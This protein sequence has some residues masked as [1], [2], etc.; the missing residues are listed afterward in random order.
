M[1]PYSEAVLAKAGFDVSGFVTC[2][3]K[4]QHVEEADLVLGLEREHR[5]Y[6]RLLVPER[7]D[8]MFT[9]IEFALLSKDQGGVTVEDIGRQRNQLNMNSEFM[10]VPDPVNRSQRAFQRTQRRIGPL[11][12]SLVTWAEQQQSQ[13]TAQPC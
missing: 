3:L 13:G 9:L 11:V 5:D 6:C 10:D 1:H 2:S 8:R 7:A 12:E 4:R